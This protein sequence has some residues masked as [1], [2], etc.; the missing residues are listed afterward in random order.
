[1][2]TLLPPISLPTGSKVVSLEEEKAV[3]LARLDQKA[4]EAKFV[5]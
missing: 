2:R 3:W 5:H 1:M 4:A